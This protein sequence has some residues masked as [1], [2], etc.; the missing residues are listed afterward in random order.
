MRPRPHSDDRRLDLARDVPTTRADVDALRALRVMA[1]SWSRGLARSS[2]LGRRIAR[3][4]TVLLVAASCGCGSPAAPS[5]L[6]GDWMGRIAPSHFMFLEIRFSEV[7]GRVLGTAC[8]REFGV[9]YFSNVPVSVSRGGSLVTVT[10]PDSNQAF[11]GRV[12]G[13]ILKLRATATSY[14]DM[15]P[16]GNQCAA[17]P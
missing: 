16:G 8:K 12:D 2:S 15:V 7:E 17:V 10:F 6:V 4:S 14:V 9:V 1:A 5:A 3:L 13:G 11:S